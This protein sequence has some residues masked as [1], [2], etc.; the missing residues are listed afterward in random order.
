MRKVT[1]HPIAPEVK[2]GRVGELVALIAL[3]EKAKKC[4][5]LKIRV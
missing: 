1:G 4:I 3:S 2:E 5:R